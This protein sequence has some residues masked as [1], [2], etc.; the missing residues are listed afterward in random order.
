MIPAYM[1]DLSFIIEKFKKD[2]E[3]LTYQVN[4]RMERLDMLMERIGML[5]LLP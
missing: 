4:I 5:N 1:N 2:N 3:E